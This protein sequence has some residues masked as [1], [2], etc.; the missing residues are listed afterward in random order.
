MTDPLTDADLDAIEQRANAATEGPWEAGD[1]DWDGGYIRMPADG[2]GVAYIATH[3]QQGAD[4][5]CA[6]AEFIAHA[7]ADVPALLAEVRRLR[8]DAEQAYSWARQ[9]AD[10]Y[11][12]DWPHEG[13]CMG[14]PADSGCPLCRLLAAL[15][16]GEQ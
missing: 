10:R 12:D 7:R 14:D 4:E 1:D 5:G 13:G 11:G 8:A 9:I 3:I 6:D 2:F 15:N 16:G